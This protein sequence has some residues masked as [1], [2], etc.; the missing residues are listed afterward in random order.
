MF[1]PL[2]T[3][4][5]LRTTP[6]MNWALI[7]ANVLI[8]VAQAVV[9]RSA[10]H[11]TAWWTGYMLDPSAPDLFSFISYAFLHAGGMHIGFNMLFLY[12]FGNNVNDKMGHVGYLAFY[13]A[14][15]I[16]AGIAYCLWDKDAGPVLGASGAVAAVVGAYLVLFPRSSVTIIFLLFISVF[17]IPSLWFVAA[18]FLQDVI[19]L[20]GATDVAHSAHVGGTIFGFLI[21]FALLGM[22]LLPRDQFDMFALVKQWNRRRQYRDAVNTGWNPYA[23]VAPQARAPYRPVGGGWVTP[24]A[25]PEA[26]IDP[27]QRQIL[28][29]RARITEAITNH[30]LPTAANLYIELKTLDPQAVLTL[31]AQLD[32]ANQLA[33]EQRYPQASEA[34]DTFLRTYPKYEQTEQVELMYGIIL[35]RYLNQPAKAREALLRASAKLM[36]ENARQLAR[37]ELE[38][39]NAALAA[40]GAQPP[41]Y[42]GA[43][44]V[45]GAV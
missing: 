15:A 10:E 39:V 20:T 2:R 31:Q 9:G 5:P 4:S 22:G 14:S 11:G 12:I 3:D 23:G 34:Y 37:A 25:A 24:P 19:N 32:I 45:G 41:T 40:S 1:I 33:S 35:S 36:N 28:D 6:Y 27:R 16:M 13:L 29:L 18:F 17:E 30:Q 43:P 21:C 42:P 8:W 7:V 26:P 38:K 44:N